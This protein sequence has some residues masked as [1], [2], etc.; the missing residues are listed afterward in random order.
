MQCTCMYQA[1]NVINNATGQR[2]HEPTHLPV[3]IDNTSTAT[4]PT[5]QLTTA[6][7]RLQPPSPSPGLRPT[8]QQC[9]NTPVK[10]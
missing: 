10:L 3:V 1:L 7:L 6:G 4:R 2:P 5:L 8:Q 9:A